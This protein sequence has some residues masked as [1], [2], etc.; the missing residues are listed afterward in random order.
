MKSGVQI[1]ELQGLDEMKAKVA[2][3]VE[4][5]SQKSPPIADFVKVAQA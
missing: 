4:Q 3:I 1:F 5:W 2:P